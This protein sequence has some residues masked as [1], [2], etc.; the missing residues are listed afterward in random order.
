[1][2]GSGPSTLPADCETVVQ[3]LERQMEFHAGNVNAFWLLDEARLRSADLSADAAMGIIEQ[4]E[5]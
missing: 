3:C 2:S 5:L 1:M 4:I